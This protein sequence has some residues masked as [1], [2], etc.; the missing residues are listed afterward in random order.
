MLRVNLSVVGRI[1]PQSNKLATVTG[2]EKE[3]TS[4]SKLNDSPLRNM[5]KR[6][7]MFNVIILMF[8]INLQIQ[9]SGRF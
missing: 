8:N 7:M 6:K 1:R 2:Y 9:S 5:T 4:D 3:S